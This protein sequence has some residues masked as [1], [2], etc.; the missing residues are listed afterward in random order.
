M[1]SNNHAMFFFVDGR[2]RL[3]RSPHERNCT[4]K[5]SA[6][7]VMAALASPLHAAA[8]DKAQD[9]TTWTVD[10]SH[11]S[12]NFRV[13]HLMVSHVKGELG[14]VTGQLVLDEKNVERSRVE[15]SID[16][17]KID[18]RDA[19]R[20]EHLRSPDFLDVAK[21]PT[22]TFKST[23]VKKA[24]R[25]GLEV[26]GDLTIHGVTRPVVLSVDALPKPVNDPW[27]NTKRGATA[28]TKINR[29]DFGLAWN[30]ALEAGGVVVGETVEIEL[31]VEFAQQKPSKA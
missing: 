15:V 12:A 24:A 31:E 30:M 20:D 27:G 9:T 2:D 4:M 28:R 21:H 6:L 8:A 23:R 25:G 17:T 1:H 16:A 26:T 7:A 10:G 19:K 29:K 14:P 22:V 3:Q 13:R 5:T 11:S 18:S